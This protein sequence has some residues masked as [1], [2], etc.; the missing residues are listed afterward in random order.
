LPRAAEKAKNSAL[1]TAQTVWLPRSSP[2]VLQQ[3]SRK[4]P[5]SGRAEQSRCAQPGATAQGA[6]VRE[7][8]ELCSQ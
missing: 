3:P 7:E 5:V 1:M 2:L 8:E 6:H 4:K